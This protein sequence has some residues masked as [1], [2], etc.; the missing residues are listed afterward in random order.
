MI[1]LFNKKKSSESHRT[2]K[3]CECWFQCLRSGDFNLIDKERKNRSKKFEDEEL[4]ALLDE[5]D[6]QTHQMTAEQSL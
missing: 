2:V 6:T 4:P 5:D 1:F 3:T